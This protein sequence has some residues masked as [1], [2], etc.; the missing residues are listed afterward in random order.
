MRN[1]LTGTGIEGERST[2]EQREDS[3]RHVIRTGSGYC[4]LFPATCAASSSFSSSSSQ[5]PYQFACCLHSLLCFL[6][7]PPHPHTHSYYSLPTARINFMFSYKKRCLLSCTALFHSALLRALHLKCPAWTS[8]N[9][10]SS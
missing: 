10:D 4:C 6:H 3:L 1:A 9:S 8:E 5:L 2:G 7:T